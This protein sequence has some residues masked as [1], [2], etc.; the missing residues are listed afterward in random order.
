[1]IGVTELL[2]RDLTTATAEEL[3]EGVRSIT[4]VTA[5][6][7]EWSGRLIAELRSRG[8]TWPEV[9]AATGVPTG[10]AHRWSAPY[11]AGPTA[12]S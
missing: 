6:A 2:A 8:A 5:S 12:T 1:M 10:T 4:R 11:V 7:Q 3:A 9:E